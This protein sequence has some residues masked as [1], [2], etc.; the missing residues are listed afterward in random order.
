MELFIVLGAVLFPSL[1]WAGSSAWLGP[2]PPGKAYPPGET[3][4]QYARLEH[5]LA[6]RST[7]E[8]VAV[9]TFRRESL[10]LDSDR[11]PLDVLL[12]RTDVLLADFLDGGAR[13]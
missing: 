2:E 9:Q 4:R 5:D 13:S 1:S 7:L 12:R 10:I 8:Q 6:N 3:D 11:D